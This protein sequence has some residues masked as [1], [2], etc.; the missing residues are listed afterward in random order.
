MAAL[1]KM[2]SVNAPILQKRE[3]K[4]SLDV[5]FPVQRFFLHLGIFIVVGK[6]VQLNSWRIYS[7][8]TIF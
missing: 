5:F 3:V 1:E 4:Y 8:Q 7:S 6:L 2:S